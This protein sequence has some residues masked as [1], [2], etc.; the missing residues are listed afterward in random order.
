M[1]KKTKQGTENACGGEK[2]LKKK[3]DIPWDA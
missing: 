3:T 1:E 2:Q